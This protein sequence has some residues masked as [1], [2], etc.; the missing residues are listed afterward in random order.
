MLPQMATP[1]GMELPM[2]HA[3][4]CVVSYPA[5]LKLISILVALPSSLI[6]DASHNLIS[7]AMARIVWITVVF[8]CHVPH[9]HEVRNLGCFQNTKQLQAVEK[10]SS[11][12][13]LSEGR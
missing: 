13:Y 2:F 6:F 5:Y 8:L 1:Q 12:H 4:F 11:V 10:N 7:F 9:P 3:E